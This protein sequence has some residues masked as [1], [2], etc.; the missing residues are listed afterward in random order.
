LAIPIFS[1]FL[2]FQFLQPSL[3][4]FVY[5]C[6]NLFGLAL[7][8]E[9]F[10]CLT[11]KI[12]SHIHKPQSRAFDEGGYP[13]TTFVN[14]LRTHDLT[15]NFTQHT[16]AHVHRDRSVDVGAPIV[17]R[18]GG[19]DKVSKILACL[20]YSSES[21]LMLFPWCVCTRNKAKTKASV[22]NRYE[23]KKQWKTMET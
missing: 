13:S 23:L 18:T 15:Q 22:N 19:A 17:K 5:L 7:L 14:K 12:P 16:R 6:L 20:F 11:L 1:L 3:F 10:A 21:D 8:C 2:S 9:M 4:F